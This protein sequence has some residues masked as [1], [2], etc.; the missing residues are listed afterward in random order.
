MVGFEYCL[1]ACWQ[2]LELRNSRLQSRISTVVI[3]DAYQC[4]IF[5]WARKLIT[6]QPATWQR[7][8]QMALVQD[9]L[10]DQ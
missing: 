1:I 4:T 10:Q 5:D 6:M 8:I 2:N 9:C 7:L 3:P